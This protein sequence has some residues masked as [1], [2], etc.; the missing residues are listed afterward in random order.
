MKNFVSFYVRLAV[1]AGI[2]LGACIWLRP[3]VVTASNAICWFYICMMFVFFRFKIDNVAEEPAVQIACW[4]ALLGIEVG[5]LLELNFWLLPIAATLAASC[6]FVTR[7]TIYKKPLAYK[8]L[9]KNA[10]FLTVFN[11]ALVLI[12]KFALRPIWYYFFG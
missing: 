1:L 10:V 5:I 12:I 3:E 11:Y 7:A 6:Y 4:F 2:G 9:W 8:E